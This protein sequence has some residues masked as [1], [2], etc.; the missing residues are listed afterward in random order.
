MIDDID[1]YRAAKLLIDKHGENAG[2]EASMRADA[3][4]EQGDL[5]GKAVWLR[6]LEA[7]KELQNTAPVGPV[8]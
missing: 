5:D 7:V 6:I 8:H 4:L 1:I 2:N 3:M